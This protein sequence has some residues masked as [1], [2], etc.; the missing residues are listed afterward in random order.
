MTSTVNAPSPCSTTVR[1]TPLTAIEAPCSVSLVT[2]G[3]W[4]LSRAESAPWSRAVTVP[5][6]STM[7]VNMAVSSLPGVGR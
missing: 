4:M 5:S 2:R 3:P 1:H 6:S 7:P